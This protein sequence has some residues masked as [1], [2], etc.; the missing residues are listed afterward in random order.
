MKSVCK[1]PVP[2]SHWYFHTGTFIGQ[3]H[4]VTSQM[5]IFFPITGCVYIFQEEL[6]S[7]K[8]NERILELIKSQGF[9]AYKKFKQIL[10]ETKQTDLLHRIKE[11]EDQILSEGIL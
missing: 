8:K 10:F 9:E 2:T 5:G 11:T 6:F 7:P 3:V 4:F 1:Y